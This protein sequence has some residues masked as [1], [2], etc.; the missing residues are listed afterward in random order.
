MFQKMRF[1]MVSFF[2]YFTMSLGHDRYLN[3]VRKG[4]ENVVD[5]AKK[6]R[7]IV[8]FCEEITNITEKATQNDLQNILNN[9]EELQKSLYLQEYVVDAQGNR[10]AENI[11]LSVVYESLELNDGAYILNEDKKSNF[12]NDI[13]YLK[14]L[15]FPVYEMQFSDLLTYICVNIPLNNLAMD[16]FECEINKLKEVLDEEQLQEIKELSKNYFRAAILSAHID[17]V[18][19]LRLPKLLLSLK[20]TIDS[21]RAISNKLIYDISSIVNPF[22]DQPNKENNPNEFDVKILTN[23][24]QKIDNQQWANLNVDVFSYL[25]KQRTFGR[26]FSEKLNKLVNQL[27]ALNNKFG[28]KRHFEVVNQISQEL[29]QVYN[30]FCEDGDY[31]KFKEDGA[32]VFNSVLGNDGNIDIH[33]NGLYQFLHDVGLLSLVKWLM[34]CFKPREEVELIFE[35]PIKKVSQFFKDGEETQ[36]QDNSLSDD[37]ELLNP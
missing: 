21:N 23:L 26:V 1:G 13:A 4:Y 25:L 29:S 32:Q 22:I 17:S 37:E 15:G 3:F 35:T 10:I 9:S 14:E 2:R 27:D 34:S 19:Y 8:D 24:K 33:T 18:W 30:Q 5:H 28:R 16:L 7:K 6:S 11:P 31:R 20:Q 36:I 12:E